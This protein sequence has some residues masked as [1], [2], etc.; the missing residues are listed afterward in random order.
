MARKCSSL[1]LP[2]A[3]QRLLELRGFSLMAMNSKVS[4]DRVR[5]PYLQITVGPFWVFTQ[6]LPLLGV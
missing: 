3:L 2:G 6:P 4:G 1:N 5:L